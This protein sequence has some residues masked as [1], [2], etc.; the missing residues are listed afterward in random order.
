MALSKEY[1]A[2]VLEQLERTG[3]VTFKS[4]FGGA[5]LYA[6]GAFFGLISGQDVFYLKV[7]DATRPDYQERGCE[8]FAPFGE[9][10]MMNYFTVPEEV[11]EDPD[12]LAI[13]ARKSIAVAVRTAKPKKT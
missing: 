11:L 3:P 4:M 12:E 8:P 10:A 7:D 13:W 1:R 9:K 5:G 6:D 2:Y